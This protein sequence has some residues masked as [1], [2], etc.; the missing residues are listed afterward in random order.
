MI[1]EETRNN[2]K[3]AQAEGASDA[4]LPKRQSR[5]KQPAESKEGDSS[6]GDPY[7]SGHFAWA[8]DEARE[9]ASKLELSSEEKT[10]MEFIDAAEAGDIPL[11]SCADLMVSWNPGKKGSTH[12]LEQARFSVKDVVVTLRQID[13]R[14]ALTEIAGQRIVDF[15][16]HLLWREYLLRISS[17]A[18]L[19]NKDIRDRM[20]CNGN[21][22]DKA[23]ITK[24]IG[25]ALGQKQ[26]QAPTR[27]KKGKP[28][29]AAETAKAKARRD[30]REEDEAYYIG[31]AED[32][33]NYTLFFGK[34]TSH[35]TQ[36][37]TTRKGQMPSS[38]SV[39]VDA[40]E[41][42]GAEGVA[43]PSKKRKKREETTESPEAMELDG[44]DEE[45]SGATTGA[46]ADSDF[47]GEDEK[48]DE[49]VGDAVSV[50]SDTMLDAMDED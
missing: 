50:Q 25:A 10:P 19:G 8:T 39:S 43:G 45:E 5:K 11:E 17:E 4:D 1:S 3:K 33:D 31:N 27:M 42:S 28:Q 14:E 38:D 40:A 23:T 46:E 16:P 49:D 15:C 30:A 48:E 7:H 41:R 47:E 12:K 29:T 26:Q 9:K 6:T 13:Q 21:H 35:R 20:S 18:G 2:K 32:F 24:R 37:K 36:A 44:S 34:R 22:A